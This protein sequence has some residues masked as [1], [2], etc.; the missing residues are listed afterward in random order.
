M[1]AV[2]AI[3]ERALG[4]LSEAKMFEMSASRKEY[5][6]NVLRPAQVFGAARL[7]LIR[8]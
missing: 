8:F 3:F 6:P 7:K 1:C 4:L 2:S 5:G